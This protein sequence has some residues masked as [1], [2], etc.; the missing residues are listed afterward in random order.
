MRVARLHHFTEERRVFVTSDAKLLCEHGELASSIGSW[1]SK[2]QRAMRDGLEPPPRNSVCDC[3]NTDGLHWTKE[4]PGP[5]DSVAPP[6]STLYGVLEALDAFKVEVRGRPLRQVPHT[7]GDDALFVSRKG[8]VLCCRHGTSLSAL[9]GMRA[10]KIVK[11]RG[12]PCGCCV[13]QPPR[14]V[15]LMTSKR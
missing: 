11:A 6:A 13:A 1:L 10:G 5:R 4:M 14:R 9:R 3:Q 7:S 15:G 2:E 8:G 12:E